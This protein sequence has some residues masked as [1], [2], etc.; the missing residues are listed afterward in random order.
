MPTQKGLLGAAGEHYVLSCLLR[1]GYTAGFA[2][3][4]TPA[5]D[6]MVY[7]GRCQVHRNIQVKTRNPNRPDGAWMMGRSTRRQS[8]GC[9]S[10]SSPFRRQR[11]VSTTST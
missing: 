8:P 1:Q 7:D 5:I 11:T 4:G 6:I 9:S 3:P 2:P 10:A